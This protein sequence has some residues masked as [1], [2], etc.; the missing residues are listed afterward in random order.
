MNRTLH[1]ELLDVL[2]STDPRAVHSR[3]D[4]RRINALMGNARMI[5]RFIRKNLD[6]PSPIIAEI[7]SGDG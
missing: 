5:H 1:P 7:G 4:L 2:P 3:R 6:C